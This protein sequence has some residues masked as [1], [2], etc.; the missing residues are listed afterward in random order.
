MRFF[1]TGLL[2]AWLLLI[3]SLLWDPVTRGLTAPDN[4]GSPFR[5]RA[6]PVIVQ[7][8]PLAAEPYAMG[9]RIFWTMALPL[10]PL[11]LMFFGHETWRRVCPL[12][13]FS[14]IPT[15]LGRQRQLRRL[16][17]GS[18][19]VERVLALLPSQS[20]L[21]QNHLYFQFGFLAL[22]VLGRI[23]FYNSDRIALALAF[24]F[25]L[26]F[27][28]LVG[29]LYGGKTWC[30]YFCPI[31][32]IQDIYTGPG[33]L[34]DSKA[35]IEP[36]PIGQ[37]MCRAPGAR[38]DRSICVGCTTHCPD[39]DLEN[40]YWRSIE[41]DAKRFMYYGFFGLIFAFYTYYFVYSGG[42]D[43]YMSGAW[44]HERAQLRA[45]FAPGLYIYGTA[46]PVPKLIVA[47]LYFALCIVLA[48][49]LFVFIERRYAKF[50]ARRGEPLSKTRLRHRMLSVCAFL[51]INLFYVFAGR[52]NILL[53]PTFVG[54]LIDVLILSISVTW[55]IRS[56]ARDGDIYRRERLARTLRDQL[57]RMGFRSEDALEG[58]PIDRLSADEVYVLAKT[59]PNFTVAQKREAYR[60]ILT[61]VL[62]TGEARSV[63]SLKMLGDLRAQL[64]LTDADHNA[65]TEA[66]GVRD[67]A[68]LDAET[69]RSVEIRLR[70][71]NYRKF[72]VDQIEQG[73]A[74]GLTPAAY[75]ASPRGREAIKPARALFGI[76]DE[77]H[78]RI[79]G[80]VTR[81]E[82]RFAD[83]A[84]RVLDALREIEVARFS[85]VFDGRPEAPLVRRALLEKERP[86]IREIVGLV[87]AIGDERTARSL[88]QS[89]HALAGKEAVP[90]ISEALEGLSAEVRDAFRQMTS[91]PVFCSYLD[92]VEASRPADDVFRGLTGDR[93][94]MI[95]ALA[96]SA[97]IN[98]DMAAAQRAAADLA[99][100]PEASSTTVDDVIAGIGRNARADVVAVMAELLAV[101]VFAGLKLG[102]LADIARR[103]HVVSFSLGDQIC[104]FGESPD[105]LFVLVRGETEA[106]VAGAEGRTV[107]RRSRAGAVFG[108]LG[109]ITGRPRTATIEVVSATA[110]AIAVP[111]DIVDDLL[112]RDLHAARGILTVVSG[113]LLDA[114]DAVDEPAAA[115]A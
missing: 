19:K 100:R 64:G 3:A 95:A 25:V 115:P 96:I 57:V 66:L 71:D 111:R 4:L 102:A 99:R 47:P 36:S 110:T 112:S 28:L 113:Y 80:E 49:A 114:T 9:N 92:V 8:K 34:W 87:A 108:E 97:L 89:V 16:N 62:E 85:L 79:A 106:F 17:R 63:E 39:V 22:G 78:A 5:L 40:S 2:V 20:W 74:A 65:I 32:V 86:L 38:A 15:M 50:V 37:S 58:R 94:P 53:M 14:Q 6:D 1:R 35:H 103:A 52:P 61:E 109:V 70:H 82:S 24:A 83:A 27:A 107:F 59:L 68:L 26:G 23:L 76:S 56:L 10:V 54:K 72:L 30:N 84:R 69:A 77:D 18:G 81:D 105:Y 91:D 73:L 29:F 33:G 104:R 75:L 46:V 11:A 55:L 90:S 7:G 93:D 13:H 43:Y 101:D 42:W 67:P 60:A 88:A 44:T 51:S 12:S 45:L 41:S 21:R 31:S 48:Y 98:V